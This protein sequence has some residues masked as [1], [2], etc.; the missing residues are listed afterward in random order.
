MASVMGTHKPVTT[1]TASLIVPHKYC[2][3]LCYLVTFIH[4]TFDKHLFCDNFLK[5]NVNK[6]N[7][8]SCAKHREIIVTMLRVTAN[9]L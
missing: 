2:Y 3:F 7:R 8:C 1:Q 5:E 6:V 9:T 4:L